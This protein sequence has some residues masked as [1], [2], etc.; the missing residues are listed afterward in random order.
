VVLSG[1]SAGGIGAW[2]NVDWLQDTLP[3]AKV[4]GAPIAGFYAFAHPYTGVGHT[5][6][7]MLSNFSEGAFP[8]HIKLWQS[9]LPQNCVK[10]LG[11]ELSHRCMLSNYSA[12]FVKAPMF[13]TE[14]SSQN[15]SLLSCIVLFTTADLTA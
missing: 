10:G 3:H 4:L 7:M 5:T 6:G 1:E 12:P 15:T 9:F 14:A 13:V 11:S 8:G 2:I